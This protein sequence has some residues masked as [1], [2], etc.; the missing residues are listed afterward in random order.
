MFLD[1]VFDLG[2]AGLGSGGVEGAEVSEDFVVFEV[3]A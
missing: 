1:E 2:F 3:E